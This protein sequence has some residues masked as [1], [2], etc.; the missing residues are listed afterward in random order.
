M[1]CWGAKDT[2]YPLNQLILVSGLRACPK[3]GYHVI[4]GVQIIQMPLKLIL[5]SVLVISTVNHENAARVVEFLQFCCFKVEPLEP[6]QTERRT[7]LLTI[8]EGRN[9]YPIWHLR[10]SLFSQSETLLFLGDEISF[11]CCFESTNVCCL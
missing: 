11:T 2:R 3:R 10:C 7:D 6:K 8:K 9:H 5:K 1:L 4:I